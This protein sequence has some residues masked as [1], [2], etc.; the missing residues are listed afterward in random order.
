[1][2]LFN[3]LFSSLSQHWYV[4]VRISRSVSVCPLEFEITRVDCIYKEDKYLALYKVQSCFSYKVPMSYLMLISDAQ[5]TCL[6]KWCRPRADAAECD[7]WSG[8]TLF[9]TYPTTGSSALRFTGKISLKC[10]SY[11][12]PQIFAFIGCKLVLRGWVEASQV[13]VRYINR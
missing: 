7:V 13:S 6:S 4:E 1:M 9:A 10:L 2:W 11:L 8:F 5:Q 12:Y 3:L